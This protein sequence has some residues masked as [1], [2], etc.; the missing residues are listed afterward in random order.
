MQIDF[1]SVLIAVVALTV[2]ALPGFVLSKAK[3]LP[4]KAGEALSAL[5]LYGCQPVLIFMSFQVNYRSDIAVNILIVAAL[6]VVIHF[7]M[8]GVIYLCIRDKNNE[9]KIKLVR[10]ASLFSNCGYMGLPF[11][12]TVFGGDN[13]EIIIYAAV[14]IAVFN[15]INWTIGVYMLTGDKKAVS[16]KKVLLNP[17]IISIALGAL[18]FFAVRTPVVE[19][20]AEGTKM[21]FVLEK[22]TGSLDVIGDMVT[23]LAMT[24]IG[25]RL[26]NI[27]FRRLFFDKR[28]YVVCLFKLVIMSV[29]TMLVVAFLPIATIVKYVMFF[30]LSMPSATSTALF[31]VKFGSD[32]DAASVYVLLTMVVSVLTIPLMYL[33]FS[34]V[35]GITA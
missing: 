24:V 16:V 29:A 20:A 30:L 23:P 11:L 1:L 34:G 12:Q 22:I 28:A 31:A 18:Y 21:R 19:L 35:F 2:L 13:G 8:I 33:L 7:I 5:V 14:V 6:T 15:L 25:I 10:Y 32:G 17:T 3:V 27:S 9:S 4:E 26:S